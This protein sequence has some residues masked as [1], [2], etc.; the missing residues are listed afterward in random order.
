MALKQHEFTPESDNVD[1]Y[2]LRVNHILPTVMSVWL[3]V[4]YNKGSMSPIHHVTEWSVASTLAS[5][6]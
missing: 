5:H 6:I 3:P 2:D 4:A 1:T